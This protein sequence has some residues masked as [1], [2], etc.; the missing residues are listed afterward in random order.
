MFADRWIPNLRSIERCSAFVVYKIHL[1]LHF[2]SIKVLGA[3]VL[4]EIREQVCELRN[5]AKRL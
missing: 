3:T 5:I 1:L 2:V 4:V